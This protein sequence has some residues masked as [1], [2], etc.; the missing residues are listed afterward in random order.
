[1]S[2]LL[3]RNTHVHATGLHPLPRLEVYL[4]AKSGLLPPLTDGQL[5]QWL[6]IMEACSGTAAAT[7][8]RAPTPLRDACS[9]DPCERWVTACIL[10]S[11]CFGSCGARLWLV[12]PCV[13]L[14][15]SLSLARL[16]EAFSSQ[17][18][19]S[20]HNQVQCMYWF[21]HTQAFYVSCDW[22]PYSMSETAYFSR[23]ACSRC[24]FV[25]WGGN[26]CGDLCATG[27]LQRW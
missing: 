13:S 14:C 10:L 4:K 2:T 9:H 24:E 20:L 27:A 23:T 6:S 25:P 15:V 12:M 18:A 1:M 17:L 7:H 19:E 21:L 5:L 8:S 16:D 11:A 3:I 22:L 26:C